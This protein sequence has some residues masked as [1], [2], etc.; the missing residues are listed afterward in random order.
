VLKNFS[1]NN[2]EI[3]WNFL[4]DTLTVKNYIDSDE[5][6]E[7]VRLHYMIESSEF[8]T[9]NLKRDT[10]IV[11]ACRE[12]LHLVDIATQINAENLILQFVKNGKPLI[13]T[14]E[15]SQCITIH[16]AQTTLK[17]QAMTGKKAKVV[18]YKE[19]MSHYLDSRKIQGEDLLSQSEFTESTKRH[20]FDPDIFS[21]NILQYSQIQPSSHSTQIEALRHA[22]IISNT[23]SS[24]ME[25][26]LM[27]S[28]LKRKSNDKDSL[29]G[30]IISLKRHRSNHDTTVLTQQEMN[31][32]NE[33]MD[34]LVGNLDDEDDD[35][36]LPIMHA[37]SKVNNAIVPKKTNVFEGLSKL[38]GNV[39]DKSI[40]DIT[41]LPQSH[42]TSGNIEETPPNCSDNIIACSKSQEVRNKSQEVR[43]EKLVEGIFGQ[44][45]KNVKPLQTV[46]YCEGSDSE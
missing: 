7:S 30:E 4:P 2:N 21:R 5:D 39:V 38:S 15:T 18:T 25:V 22:E 28:P 43:K 16:Y 35:E 34:N 46:V 24:L 1:K 36:M 6:C 14:V 9:Y 11:A 10:T 41:N 37:H 27:Q 19:M 44:M 20:A 13:A 40:K 17:P 45:F 32:V 23:S 33:I 42:D 3:E 12:F 31:E 29:N 26:N 8:K